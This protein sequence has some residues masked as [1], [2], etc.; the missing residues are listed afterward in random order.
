MD[1][2]HA[3]SSTSPAPMPTCVASRCEHFYAKQREHCM[4]I[5]TWQ[6][7]PITTSY[8]LNI[9]TKHGM[10]RVDIWQ[11]PDGLACTMTSHSNPSVNHTI[12]TRNPQYVTCT[13]CGYAKQHHCYHIDAARAAVELVKIFQ[14]HEKIW[15]HHDEVWDDLDFEDSMKKMGAWI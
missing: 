12:D 15:Q 13:C 8:A 7:A 1:T 11:Y 5:Y 4:S 6:D 3:N 2:L 10:T 9:R 14:R